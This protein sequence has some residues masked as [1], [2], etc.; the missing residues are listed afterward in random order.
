[1][2]APPR[3]SS[4]DVHQRLQEVFRE[5]HRSHLIAFYGTGDEDD[6]DGPDG[7]KFHVQPVSGEL[8][9]RTLVPDSLEGDPHTAFLVPFPGPLPLDVGCM[10]AD[11]GRVF[12]LG[13]SLRLK[14]MFGASE[15]E[16]AARES[17]LARFLLETPPEGMPKFGGRLTLESLWAMWLSMWGLPEE[18]LSLESLMAWGCANAAGPRFRA[19]VPE[20]VR[21]ELLE[22]LVRRTSAPTARVIWTAWESGVDRAKAIELGLLFDGM[23]EQDSPELRNGE[24]RMWRRLQVKALGV[25][26]ES[27]RD[28]IARE[29]ADKATVAF[30]IVH[31]R[32]ASFATKLLLSAEGRVEEELVR[33]ALAGSSVLPSAWSQRL[34]AFGA[35]LDA[36]ATR[37]DKETFARVLLAWKGLEGHQLFKDKENRLVLERA[38]MAVRL[39]AWLVTRTDRAPHP[40]GST[41]SEVEWLAKWYASEGGFVD[42]ARRRARGS[43]TGPFGRGVNAVVRAADK[44]RVELDRT[45][46]KA[47]PQ[48]LR[49]GSPEQ[50]IVSIEHA[51]DRLGARFLSERG[52]RKLLVLLLDGMAWAQAV[53][54]LGSLPSWGVLNWRAVN[55]DG[56]A[57]VPVI[58]SLPTIT[59]V[60]RAAFFSG[61]RT[62]P[63]RPEPTEKDVERWAAHPKLRSLV[64]QGEAPRLLLR[65]EGHTTS[66]AVSQEALSLIGDG[67]QRIV[68]IV[69]NAI[70]ASLKADTQ[71]R[72]DWTVE[73]IQSLREL[74][75]AAQAAGRVVMLAADHGHIAADHIAS[76]P[77]STVAKSR[78]RVWE[79]ADDG[80]QECE[81]G[82]EKAIAWA[83][84][85]AHGVILLA[86]DEHRY[87]GGAH[88]GEHGGATLAEVVAPAL[89][90][91]ADGLAGRVGAAD[92]DPALRVSS[93]P[94]PSWWYPSLESAKPVVHETPAPPP[95]RRQT[96]KPM[97]AQ[98]DLLPSMATAPEVHPVKAHPLRV[99]LEAS[100]TFESLGIPAGRRTQILAAVEFLA[101]RDGEQAPLT[102]FVT[103]MGT[104]PPRARGLVDMLSERLNL[105]GFT[106]LSYDAAGDF[107]KLD[108]AKLKLLYGKS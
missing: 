91:A 3:L 64:R 88:T 22:Y 39:V 32:D 75:E 2:S 79:K 62:V 18:G 69:I 60:S 25:S 1:V 73:H 63:G 96:P 16:P 65:A 105:D 87:G 4:A 9:L 10:F 24:L 42:W 37:A 41:Y 33:S 106:L 83:P 6:V 78:W 54:I 48:W 17:A 43:A 82:F 28:A 86:D 36:A 13:R 85:G 104:V 45:F 74:L 11:D 89:L 93:F 50:V 108:A 15:V 90:V 97:R 57:V 20:D 61:K 23:R 14:R 55:G 52:D 38:D 31:G 19:S 47:L 7:T 5:K 26:A 100:E 95:K 102:A 99:M 67:E 77:A 103:A 92:E 66:G 76:V 71:Q 81:V 84:P 44:I 56:S 72:M 59:E 49:A 8:E 58:A 12:T 80:I 53:E 94:L 40:T 70:D 30:R 27:E 98:L 46:A 68:A 101:P 21:R 107:V 51:V 34:D 29:L 35:A